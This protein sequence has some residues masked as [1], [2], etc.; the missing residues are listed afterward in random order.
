MVLNDTSLFTEKSRKEVL[1]P[2]TAFDGK[3]KAHLFVDGEFSKSLRKW[4][5]IESHEELTF[6]PWFGVFSKS[7]GF[8][9]KFAD[10]SKIH[11]KESRPDRPPKFPVM[12]D[13]TFLQLDYDRFGNKTMTISEME[14]LA[15][16]KDLH[17]YCRNETSMILGL[18]R[19]T[20]LSCYH[21]GCNSKSV[22]WL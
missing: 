10:R 12:A 20:H 19:F 17:V 18:I 21:D 13:S 11:V 6:L 5:R 1:E 14:R 4:F 22:A 8:L 3:M 7:P 16:R 2:Y 9:P 15:D